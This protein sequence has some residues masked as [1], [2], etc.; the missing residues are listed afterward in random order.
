[1]RSVARRPA[2][3]AASLALVVGGLVAA[4][5]AARAESPPR[6]ARFQAGVAALAAGKPEEAILALEAARDDG[7]DDAAVSFDL[8]LAYLSRARIAEAP[9]D[10]GRAV[11]SFEEARALAKS[12]PLRA[13]CI[14]L[15]G[16]V[17]S[18]IAKRRARVGLPTDMEEAPPP[19]RAFSQVLSE[20]TWAVLALVCA[21]LLF[22]GLVA[23]DRTKGRTKVASAIVAAVSALV[24]VVSAF[25]TAQRRSDRLSLEEAII[26]ADEVRPTDDKHIVLSDAPALAA[27]T[28]VRV[29]ERRAGYAAVR[30]RG[31]DAWVPERS[32]LSLPRTP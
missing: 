17:R 5:H 8:G 11:F 21:A 3:F 2:L 23:R 30:T 20:D 12:E 19:S 6:E 22:A 32:L 27:G 26:V 9:G 4:P 25:A 7:V 18:V 13:E 14:R 10:L 28:R 16:E 24:L 15:A 31:V 1:V 29:L